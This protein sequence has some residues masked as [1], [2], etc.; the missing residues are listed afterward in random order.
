MGQKNYKN[1]NYKKN[2]NTNHT[3]Y[4]IR[5]YQSRSKNNYQK[6][7]KNKETTYP[8]DEVKVEKVGG[9]NLRKEKKHPILNFFLFLTLLSSLAYFFITLSFGQNHSNFFTTLISSIC[10]LYTS[11]A[12]DEL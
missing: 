10:L 9:V 4:P 8:K 12:A 5:E 1:N 2:N 6:Y 3:N 11:D 7:D